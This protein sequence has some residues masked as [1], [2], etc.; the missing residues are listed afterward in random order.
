MEQF[1]QGAKEIKPAR[2]QKNK[3]NIGTVRATKKTVRRRG[4]LDRKKMF[5]LEQIM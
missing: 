1:T 2:P 3:I 5:F 4:K